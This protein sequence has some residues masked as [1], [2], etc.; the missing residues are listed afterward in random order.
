MNSHDVI[1]RM[2]QERLDRLTHIAYRL[3]ELD[4]DSELSIQCIGV[5]C[6][7]CPFNCG[8]PAICVIGAIRERLARLEGMKHE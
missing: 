7:E 6:S 2:R 4:A 3:T 1:K 5:P 8:R